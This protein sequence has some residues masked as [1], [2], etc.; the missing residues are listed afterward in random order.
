MENKTLEP[1]KADQQQKQLL[2]A[3]GAITLLSIFSGII[4]GYYVL[5]GLPVALLI[6][7]ITLV[8]FRALFFFLL[9]MIPFSTEVELPGGFGTD[10]PA[11][12]FMILL[13]GVFGIFVLKNGLK[14]PFNKYLI[15]P[16]SLALL[17]HL[18]WIFITCFS[19]GEPFVS[20]KFFLAKSWY[21]LTFFALAAYLI[22]TKADQKKFFWW[23]ILPM[24]F[25]MLFI[26]SKHAA[27]GFSFADSNRVV[28]PFYR[29]HVNYASLLALFFP[30][31]WAARFWYKKKTF[32]NRLL[33]LLIP[34]FLFAIQLSFTRASYLAILMAVGVY[35]IIRFHLMKPVLIL[36]TAVLIGFAGYVVKND[37][38]LDYAPEYK[39]TV[40]HYNFD[41]LIEAT[42]KGED[43]STMER[44]YRWV[45][46]MHMI[47]ERPLMGFGPGNFYNFYRSYTVTSFETYVSDNPEKSGIHSYYLMT[48][49]EQGA[50]G[51][52]F[53]GILCFVVLAYGELIYHQTKDVVQK[54][55]I[56]ACTLSFF[57]ILA[58]CL[59][60]DLVETDKVGP[61]FFMN[62]AFLLN[63][64]IKNRRDQGT[65]R[66]SA[67]KQRNS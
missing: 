3:F 22:R 45:A 60:N 27:L 23:I 50:P 39:K 62:M 36:G 56:M 33:L 26:I 41:N 51:L 37:N 30:Y 16:I 46:G 21:V 19:S 43:I 13:S 44:V 1:Q 65:S 48:M 67:V 25:T 10:L 58:L 24:I 40:T 61:F 57:I 63:Q 5:A 11:E 49:V 64:D 32:K 29:N 9:A 15:H 2:T 35:F 47:Q 28:R 4:S 34:F 54:K 12:P 55:W 18:F 7:Y 20:I 6:G 53:F 42:Y 14:L 38:Y 17:A 59:I 8:D 66:S 31:I 52:L